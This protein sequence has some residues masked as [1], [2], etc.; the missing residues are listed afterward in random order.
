MKER[1]EAEGILERVE[2][3]KQSGD[4][5]ENGIPYEWYV[6]GSNGA[7]F[8]LLVGEGHT[9]KDIVAAKRWLRREHDPVCIR[10]ERVE[11]Y[12]KEESGERS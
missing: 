2:Y 6:T 1:V 9:M 11:G 4:V 10:W 8:I 12:K 3:C 7:H 5:T